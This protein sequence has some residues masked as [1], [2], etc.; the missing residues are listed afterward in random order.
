MP[1]TISG[2]GG[3]SG[4][5]NIDGHDLET[6]TL[7]VSGD[8]T[9][10]PQAVGRS[11]LF[12]EEATN[13][14]GINTTTPAAAVFLEVAD[15]TDPIVSLNNTG[16]GEVRLGCDS[17][18]GYI[19]TESNHPFALTMNGTTKVRVNTD[20][21][22]DFLTNTNPASFV[23]IGADSGS[24]FHAHI[25]NNNGDLILGSQQTTADTILTSQRAINFQVNSASIARFRG[26][27]SS[28][29]FILHTGGTTNTTPR[30]TTF[31][32][33]LWTGSDSNVTYWEFRNENTGG[34]NDILLTHGPTGNYGI[35]GHE[36]AASSL[37]Q[38]RLRFSAGGFSVGF[39]NA[40]GTLQPARAGGGIDF[41]LISGSGSATNTVTSNLLDDYEE[42]TWAPSGTNISTSGSIYIK[43]GRLVTVTT[44]I[45]F[46]SSS[47][48]TRADIGGL[49]FTP[50]PNISNSAMGSSVGET[51]Y[52]GTDRPW[53]G[54]EV[55]G[56]IR[57]RLDGNTSMTYA[58][59]SSKSVR[60]SI[61]YFANA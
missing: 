16:N 37:T 20:A 36:L 30:G 45:D 15:G 55:G 41:S 5:G 11:T 54:V 18:E 31:T 9:I 29:A 24:A 47:S 53:A 1:I 6:A 60:L 46:G 57:F 49:P 22:V 27:D 25:L 51:T 13:T 4:L 38:D 10:A 56:V 17:A 61:T 43:V 26:S 28:L 23:T 52:T 48:T 39:W 33:T 59:W 42:G 8:T 35:V 44:R 21:S 34:R 14:V 19:G 40:D 32:K 58:D 2:N 12:I 50:D 3:I 7:V